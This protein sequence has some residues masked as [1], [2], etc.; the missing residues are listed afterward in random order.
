MNKIVKGGVK[1][2]QEGLKTFKIVLI[3]SFRWIVMMLTGIALSSFIF[4]YSMTKA[5]KL[6]EG[7]DAVGFMPNLKAL[8]S[9]TNFSA[10]VILLI[11]IIFVILYFWIANRY[12]IQKAISLIWER[13]GSSYFEN[14]IGRLLGYLEAKSPML[15]ANDVINK[16]VIKEELISLNNKTA[17]SNFVLR[18][19]T[20]YIVKK[21]PLGR[22][23]GNLVQQLSSVKF[24]PA[25]LLPALWGF[26]ALVILQV[27]MII[28]LC[29][30][31]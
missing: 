16:D 18:K 2:G 15:F 8:F 22:K 9:D 5:Y 10:I 26:Y 23:T 6:R 30:Y 13:Q 11:Q 3:C 27:L 14:Y 29:F 25:N 12:A 19:S 28:Y 4:I 24:N 7:T 31:L 1:L 17:V 20:N 21:A